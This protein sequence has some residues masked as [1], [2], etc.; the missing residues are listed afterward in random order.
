MTGVQTCALPI[1]EAVDTT[2][3]AVET[4]GTVRPGVPVEVADPTMLVQIL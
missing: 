3:E 1:L 2:V 4:D